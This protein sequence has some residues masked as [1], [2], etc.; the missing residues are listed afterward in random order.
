MVIFIKNFDLIN[1]R[2]PW[3]PEITMFCSEVMM[4][5]ILILWG[6]GHPFQFHIYFKKGLLALACCS[7]FTP[8]V[9]GVDFTSFWIITICTSKTVASIASSTYYTFYVC[10]HIHIRFTRPVHAWF[11]NIAFVWEVGMH[12][13]HCEQ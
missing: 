13:C 3:A 10:W 6:L 2:R 5:K 1:I 4:I 12:V 7:F 8:G 11:F 9:F